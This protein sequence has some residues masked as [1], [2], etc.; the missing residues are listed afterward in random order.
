[1]N[2][3]LLRHFEVLGQRYALT[4]G[5]NL[6][7]Y[8]LSTEIRDQVEVIHVDF[9]RKIA[10][11]SD[12]KSLMQMLMLLWRI[13]PDAIHSI[14]PKAGLLAMLVG[15]VMGTRLRHHTFTGQVWTNK[16][17]SARYALKLLDKLTSAL[18]TQ[19]FTD[20][21]SQRQFLIREGIVASTRV[22]MLGRGSIAGV[23][24]R[25]FRPDET[26]RKQVRSRLA[27]SMDACVFIFVGR[28]V[29]DKG[30]FE[31]MEAFQ[32]VS[33]V[34]PDVELW[35][36]GPDEDGLLNQ[37]KDLGRLVS[38]QVR[39][40]GQTPTP[41]L[42]MA[43]ADV[44]VLPSYREGF[45]SVVIEAAACGLPS[46][47]SRI[48][49]IVDAVVDG[50]TGLLV[51]VRSVTSLSSAMMTL[52]ENSQ[53]RKELGQNALSRATQEFS[54]EAVTAEWAHFYRSVL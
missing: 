41:E 45:G 10:L 39:W 13:R 25:R 31:L 12:I 2:A 14:T 48:D 42:Y 30:L 23:D 8:P 32:N 36:V 26:M 34:H 43:A 5:V 53:L 9:Q 44:I 22:S 47:A 6:N 20:S 49:G 21:A 18:S 7:L 3:F 54:S 29:R 33:E 1:M 50:Q 19:V 38:G 15:F 40:V 4:L 37:L 51:E 17:G 27:T 28:L 46:I 24:L 11:W 52:C 35:V 16:R